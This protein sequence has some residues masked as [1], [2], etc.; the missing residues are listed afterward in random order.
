MLLI[1]GGIGVGL[2]YGWLTARLLYRARWMSFVCVLLWLIAQGV[3]ILKLTSPQVVLW[4][5]GALIISALL[6]VA[7]RRVLEARYG[8]IG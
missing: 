5:S 8:A 1:L 3:L 6:C 4:F 7:W 2:V